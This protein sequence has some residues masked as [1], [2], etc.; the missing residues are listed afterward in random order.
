[1]IFDLKRALHQA[2]PRTV[3]ARDVRLHFRIHQGRQA[4]WIEQ[5]ALGMAERDAGLLAVLD[6]LA[7]AGYTQEQI[8]AAVRR[9]HQG[10]R[11]EA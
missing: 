10:S 1:M 11:H 6:K 5:A 4:A 7:A 8:D 2:M 9:F 3:I